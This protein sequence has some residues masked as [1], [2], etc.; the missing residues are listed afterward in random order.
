M[1]IGAHLLTAR[2]R[3]VK[4]CSRGPR[5][6][7][8][9]SAWSR[10]ISLWRSIL[11]LYDKLRS[12]DREAVE[13]TLKRYDIA[14]TIFAPRNRIVAALDR[15][16]GWRRLDADAVAVGPVR[17]RRLRG[18]GRGGF[19]G[20][21]RGV[22]FCARLFLFNA[23][24][25]F[26]CNSEKMRTDPPGISRRAAIIL[27]FQEMSRICRGKGASAARLVTHPCRDVFRSGP[28]GRSTARPCA[29]LGDAR[30]LLR[31][32]PRDGQGE[33]LRSQ[34]QGR[35]PWAASSLLRSTSG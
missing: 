22:Q 4:R 16:P 25:S 17:A 8:H 31:A 33:D 2:A 21:N 27:Q 24:T 7:A 19:S 3:A 23:L 1:A 28:A 12:A 5:R 15:E 9:Q 34:P 14:W 6:R 13:I 30:R 20:Q 10:R 32:S 18:G 35:A 26:F 29:G 11:S